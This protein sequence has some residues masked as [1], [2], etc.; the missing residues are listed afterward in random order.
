MWSAPSEIG[1]ELLVDPPPPNWPELFA[2][3]VQVVQA[4][5]SDAIAATMATVV[6][7]FKGSPPPSSRESSQKAEETA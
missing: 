4:V 6:S 1:T 3:H 2:P 5:A 7:R